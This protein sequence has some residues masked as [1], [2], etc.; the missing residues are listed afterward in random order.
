MQ[1]GKAGRIGGM[2][3]A[4]EPTDCRYPWNGRWKC[5]DGGASKIIY[6]YGPI[7]S[8]GVMILFNQG[9]ANLLQ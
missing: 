1:L 9:V 3:K 7:N 4:V 5:K 8:A 6:C 2:Q